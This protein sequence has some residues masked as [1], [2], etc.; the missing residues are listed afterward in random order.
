MPNIQK[1]KSEQTSSY[2]LYHIV[3]LS[4]CQTR[5]NKEEALDILKVKHKGFSSSVF[6]KE[7]KLQ[8]KDWFLCF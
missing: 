2:I 1:K 4:E 5:R 3:S 7:L 6:A 8:N